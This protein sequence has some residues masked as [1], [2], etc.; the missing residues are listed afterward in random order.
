MTIPKARLAFFKLNVEDIESALAFWQQAFGFA[1][2][3]TLDEP[4]FVEHILALPDQESGPKL[5]LVEMKAARDVSVGPGHGPVG[6]VCEDIAA[7]FARA[8]EQG[9]S[10]MLE[11]FTAGDVQ[12]AMLKSPQGHEI[13]LVQLPAS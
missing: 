6:L 11:P 5:M 10:S 12:V 7:S 2:V 9:A 1:I 13:E 3:A 4:E 8:I